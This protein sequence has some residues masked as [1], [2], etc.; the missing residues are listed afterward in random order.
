MADANPPQVID[1]R[2]RRAR[3]PPRLRG[4]AVVGWPPSSPPA[5]P[6]PPPPPAMARP[7]PALVCSGGGRPSYSPAA[8][9]LLF[10]SYMAVRSAALPLRCGGVEHDVA[11][12]PAP[13]QSRSLSPRIPN[14]CPPCPKLLSTCDFGLCVMP[15]LG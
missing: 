1:L 14:F 9:Q 6:A 12:T 8:A 15:T 7:G 11:G 10:L 5:T 3:P 4:P 13:Q 2:W